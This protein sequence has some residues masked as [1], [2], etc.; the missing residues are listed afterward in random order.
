[1]IKRQSEKT[2]VFV[3]YLVFGKLTDYF[4]LPRYRQERLF[5]KG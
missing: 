4:F 5:L 2:V 3:F 1:M